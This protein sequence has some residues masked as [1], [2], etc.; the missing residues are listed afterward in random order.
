M[1]ENNNSFNQGRTIGDNG[2]SAVSFLISL[3]PDWE[4]IKFGI[5]NHIVTLKETI[6]K[7]INP[8]ALKIKSMPDF[9]VFNTKT[10][11]TFLMEV[12]YRSNSKKGKYLFKYLNKYNEYWKGTK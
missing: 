6:R 11:E 5:E 1:T 10:R 8:I 2:E 12:K 3:V 7:D 4:C 9:V